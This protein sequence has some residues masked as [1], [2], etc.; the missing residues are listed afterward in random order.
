MSNPGLQDLTGWPPK[1]K[2]RSGSGVSR[3]GYNQSKA[4]RYAYLGSMAPCRGRF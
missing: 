3:F 4:V 1:G 2:V